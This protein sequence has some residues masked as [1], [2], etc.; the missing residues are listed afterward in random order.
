MTQVISGKEF[1]ASECNYHLYTT[2]LEE[3]DTVKFYLKYFQSFNMGSAFW[4][5]MLDQLP[6]ICSKDEADYSCS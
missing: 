1:E 6:G 2:T 4:I 3:A 5:S